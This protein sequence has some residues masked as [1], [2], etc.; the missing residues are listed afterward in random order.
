VQPKTK[1]AIRFCVPILNTKNLSF[2]ATKTPHT[3][4]AANIYLM[5]RQCLLVRNQSRQ[6]WNKNY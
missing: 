1:N 4:I 3:M 5:M 2:L 6:L